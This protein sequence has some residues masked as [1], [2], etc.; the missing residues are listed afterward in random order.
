MAPEYEHLAVVLDWDKT[1]AAEIQRKA[2]TRRISYKLSRRTSVRNR[3]FLPQRR[4]H[5]FCPQIPFEGRMI[6]I[7]C[8]SES[9]IGDLVDDFAPYGVEISA[10][11]AGEADALYR[12]YGGR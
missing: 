4:V 7:G 2:K 9:P 10:K 5:K 8:G 3:R 11:L 6:D 12:H 1:H